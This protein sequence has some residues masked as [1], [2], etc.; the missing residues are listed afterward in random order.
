MSA[1]LE[2]GAPVRGPARPAAE[3]QCAHCGL[4]VPAARLE[5]LNAAQF[6]CDGCRAV[7]AILHDAGL[8]QYY[9]Q[10][11]PNAP[12][13]RTPQRSQRQF[14]E[15]D[16][17]AFRAGHCHDR[18]G[19]VLQ[20]EFFVEGVHCSACVWLLE[21]LPR[22]ASAVLEARYDLTRSV[23]QI[24]W[25]PASAPLSAIA[26]ALDSLGYT[27]HPAHATSL[28]AEQRQ[29]DRALLLRL[30]IAGAA[31]GNVML[32][33]LALYSGKYAGMATEY[34]ELFRW[35]SLAIATPAVF[36]AG[37][38]FFRGGLAAL[39]TRTPHMD[40]PV[41]LGLLAGYVGSTVNT[42]RGQ[43]EVYF[44]SLCTLIFLLLVGRYLQRTH[45]RRST[46][47]S[48][49]L[50]ALAPTT[51]WLVDGDGLREVPANTVS[52]GR[53]VEIRA[54]ERVAVDGVVSDGSSALDASLLT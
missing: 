12:E 34:A 38:L 5:P 48:D 35:G 13:A 21:R 53:F 23:L 31:A 26:R 18:G 51:A 8:E 40:L 7:F 49:L 45:Q 36:W 6:C 33:A 10:R 43:G 2:V 28:A 42:L 16:E 29:G 37:S 50:N 46:K 17:P 41:S 25:D 32:M 54:G 47:A 9:D 24:S 14:A 22:V 30:G 20:T 1:A 15:L 52:A 11:V 4:P 39:R 27:P 3:P 44:D 19:G